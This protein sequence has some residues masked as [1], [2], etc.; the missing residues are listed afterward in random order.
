MP[1]FQTL[2][3]SLKSCTDFFCWSAR[4]KAHLGLGTVLYLNALRW[5]FFMFFIDFILSI[6]NILINAKGPRYT[7]ASVNGDYLAFASTHLSIANLGFQEW[8]P[9]NP[10][11]CNNN[12]FAAKVCT[13]WS[14]SSIDEY[15]Y[16]C[17]STPPE[18]SLSIKPFAFSILSGE[19]NVLCESVKTACSCF[20]GYSGNKCEIANTSFL[21][22][23]SLSG[24]VQKSWCNSPIKWWETQDFTKR[25]ELL[26]INSN[27]RLSTIC[28]GHGSCF[29]R[30]STD[31][32]TLPLYSFCQCDKGFYGQYCEKTMSGLETYGSIYNLGVGSNDSKALGLCNQGALPAIERTFVF[33]L[34]PAICSSHG[35]GLYMPTR[36]D[37]RLNISNAYRV[38][39]RGVCF[40]EPA[41]TGEECLG[42]EAI[43]DLEGYLM[44]VHSLFM[45]IVCCLLYQHRKYL[46]QAVD[47][48]NVSPRDFSIFVNHLPVL[49]STKQS[50]IQRVWK[51]FEQFGP[52]HS[53]VPATT[54]E[55]IFYFQCEQNRALL[56]LQKMLERKVYEE[57]KKSNISSTVSLNDALKQRSGRNIVIDWK[58]R[59]SWFPRLSPL[60]ESKIRDSCIFLE[61]VT[62]S[63]CV[64]VDSPTIEAFWDSFLWFIRPLSWL[65]VTLDY[66]PMAALRSLIRHL[67]GL[68]V[69]EV[70]DP[71]TT[72]FE[73]AFITFEHQASRDACLNA[74]S[75]RAKPHVR[76][77]GNFT[78]IESETKKRKTVNIRFAKVEGDSSV[79]LVEGL[80]KSLQRSLG[81]PSK[82]TATTTTTTESL[83]Y[84]SNKE[85]NILDS[86]QAIT[87][88]S[89]LN[90]PIEEKSSKPS[91][92]I[93]VS[94]RNPIG[95]RRGSKTT[96]IEPDPHSSTPIKVMIAWEPDEVIWDALDTSPQELLFR[97]IL[98]SIYMFIVVFF[99]FFVITTVNARKE[100]GSTGFLVSLGVVLLNFAIAAHWNSVADIE[101]N[102]SIGRKSRSIFTK[103]LFAQIAVTILSGTIGVYGYPVDAKNGY[104]QDW[105]AEAG[106]FLFNTVIIEAILP[107][108]LVLIPIKWINMKLTEYTS[109]YTSYTE[110]MSM[111]VP[112]P[113]ALESRCASLVRTVFLCCAFQSGLPVLNIACAA[114]LFIRYISDMY[115]MEFLVRIQR[116]GAELAR[117]IEVSLILATLLLACMSW[118]LL[119]AGQA[120][121][122]LHVN[123][124]VVFFICVFFIIWAL[125]GYFSFK[126]FQKRD[127]CL[128][129]GFSRIPKKY[130]NP[131][132][133]L[134]E[135]FMRLI[136]G[137]FFF[138]EHEDTFDETDGKTYSELSRQAQEE[139]KT[140]LR[141]DGQVVKKECLSS[142]FLMRF[143]PYEMKERTQRIGKTGIGIGVDNT[144]P[145]E[146]LIPYA[147]D[148]TAL[149]MKKWLE[150][151]EK[152]KQEQIEVKKEDDEEI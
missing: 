26:T 89:T 2:P 67:E 123:A 17:G 63:H 50:D 140:G 96:E 138:N 44:C 100:T 15:D 9:I 104:I 125:S 71:E 80:G 33:T 135:S 20:E 51:H 76:P 133:I 146:D 4:D 88:I 94:S 115:V 126:Q 65:I 14:S 49:K 11:A 103:V 47:D 59:P 8:T 148:W 23:K 132:L 7:F 81:T 102:Y 118:V 149:H 142:H 79:S 3:S 116:S 57:R 92:S 16:S 129:Y 13:S 82:M 36:P 111:R 31:E 97:G 40:C 130:P 5:M 131:L 93:D 18:T 43:P 124:E 109:G 128:G 46:E 108:L 75:E 105:Y 52:V 90:T 121:T 39:S 61:P 78:F 1:L 32:M 37:G 87:P 53:V 99:L 119:R 45:A 120:T 6:P 143:I 106:G 30:T 55:N 101:Q 70:K 12:G 35:F 41:Y 86:L 58:I 19:I 98:V 141:K 83:F 42:G 10:L 60:V 74:Y 28:S 145:F 25:A 48:A 127:C 136:F 107:P 56:A 69:D 147:P 85:D 152:K 22:N 66:L 73:R 38:Q 34:P 95:R 134:H 24:K 29:T 112:P 68:L 117:A 62:P 54:D 151:I 77:S 91:S 64:G 137:D 150:A 122:A 27:L 144:A 21:Q 72:N 139:L 110:W 114:C 113:F 84:P